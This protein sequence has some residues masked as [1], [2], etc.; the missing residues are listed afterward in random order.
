M[1]VAVLVNGG[2]GSGAE[3]IAAALRENDVATLIGTQTA[4]RL[5]GG[6]LFPLDDGSTLT[7]AVQEFRSGR[8]QEIEHHG[9]APDQV[10]E[11]DPAAL[12]Q[13][14]DSQLDA[15][16]TYLRSKVGG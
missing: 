10:I 11:L 2:T 7:V 12:A 5:A 16:L 3:L 4:G 13:G 15:A 9:I 14:K 8:G 1:P 6:Q